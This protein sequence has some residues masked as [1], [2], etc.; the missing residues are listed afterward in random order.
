VCIQYTHTNTH[1]TVENDHF[2]GSLE[3]TV[4]PQRSSTRNTVLKLTFLHSP[5]TLNQCCP[6]SSYR[7]TVCLTNVCTAI[8][9][10]YGRH[11]ICT[12]RD[13]LFLIMNKQFQSSIKQYPLQTENI[14]SERHQQ[15]INNF[16]FT[17]DFRCCK[18]VMKPIWYASE[19]RRH[20][21][22]TRQFADECHRLLLGNYSAVILAELE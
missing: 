11:S 15:D 14:H 5:S 20:V 18:S 13:A 3:L 9:Y 7:N 10:Y 4:C 21:M 16:K 6:P 22:T 17:F 8:I 1:T 2:L 12:D 19:R